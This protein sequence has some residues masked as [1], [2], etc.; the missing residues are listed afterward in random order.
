MSEHFTAADEIADTHMQHPHV[1][2]LGAGASLAASPNGD[3]FGRRLP[4]MNN[5]VDVVGLL[6]VLQKHGLAHRAGDNFEL[7]Y[8]ALHEDASRAHLVAE[9][10]AHV[11]AYFTA[12][13]LPDVATIYDRL[14]LS[15]RSKDVI[16]T[17]NWDP[18]LFEAC[19][20]NCR[21]APMPRL[22]FLHDSVSVGYCSAHRQ[23]GPRAGACP[24]CETPFTPSRLLYPIAQ[25]NYTS[26]PF[27]AAEWAGLRTALSQ[28]FAITIFGYGA[29]TS[30]LEAVR[31][32]EEA[33]GNVEDRELEQTEIID[34]RSEDDL[35]ETW[36]PFIHTHHYDI[37]SAFDD[38]WI[39]HHPRRSCEA[40]W[41]QNM[42]VRFVENNPLPATD[43]L[44]ELRSWFADLLIAEH[45]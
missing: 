23:K 26:D 27:I 35:K 29:P 30:D 42:D 8:S 20:R 10:E 3:R 5:F 13:Q 7:L 38:S 36:N 40:L 6:P 37:H 28:A 44:S 22:I 11:H 9:I 1:V 14:V 18:F 24:K 39:R 2:I 41:A 15:L 12:M 34:I 32:M 43:D 45:S 33:W 16:A 4:L 17:F 25:K 21:H 19:R 31:L